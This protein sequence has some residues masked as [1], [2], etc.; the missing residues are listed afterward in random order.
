MTLMTFELNDVKL[1]KKKV[2][3]KPVQLQVKN[4]ENSKLAAICKKCKFTT[5]G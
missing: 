3:N 5:L 4:K 2:R 1:N